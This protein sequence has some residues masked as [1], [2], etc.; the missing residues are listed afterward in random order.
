ML[1]AIARSVIRSIQYSQ[2]KYH[3]N[4]RHLTS[5]VQFMGSKLFTRTWDVSQCSSYCDAQTKYNL[6]TAPKYG[7]PAKVCKFCNTYLLQA[8][9]ANGRVVHKGQYCAS[10]TYATNSREWREQD[11]YTVDY[12][13][14]YS[15]ASSASGIDPAVGD[16]NGAK[17]QAVADIKWS[18]LQPFCSNDLGY[19]T[20]LSTTTATAT[21]TSTSTSIFYITTTVPLPS[22]L[23]PLR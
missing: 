14:G 17:F 13:F 2:C 16:V 19:T 5:S 18:S 10:K 7:T 1:K 4:V 15:K 8:K 23:Q 3:T 9:L 20:P 22:S 21:L 12:S 11:Q 6:A